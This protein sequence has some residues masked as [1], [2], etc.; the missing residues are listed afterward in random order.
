MQK[1]FGI[2]LILTATTGVLFA[3]GGRDGADAPVI[4]IAHDSSDDARV[5]VYQAVFQQLVDEYN[6]KNGTRY[7]LNYVPGQERDIINTRMSSNDKPDLFSLD[8]PADVNQYAQEGLLLD[9]TPYAD[10]ADWKNTLFGWAYDL[11]KVNDRVVTLPYGYEGMV[12]W[13]NKA[14]MNELGLNPADIGTLDEFEAAME[15]AADAGYIPVMLG[16]QDQ[17]WSQEWYLSILYSYTGRD[18]LKATIEGR[19]SWNDAAFR[20]TVELYRSW[21][22][23]GFLADGKSYVLTIDDAIN[24]FSNDKALF[25]VEGTWAPYWILPLDA[26]AQDKI[27]VMLHPA[28][29]ASERPHM[30]LAVGGMWCVSRDTEHA[31]IAAYILSSL[32]RQEFQGTFIQT[33]MDVAPMNIDTA[34]FR[35]LAPFVER[36]WSIV[37]GALAEGSFGYTTWAFYPPETRI[38]LYEGIVSVLEEDITVDEYLAELQR[39]NT[40]ELNAG[41]TPVIPAATN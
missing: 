33:G 29:N 8:S 40:K 1:F 41:F 6:Q 16:T 20:R 5:T 3:S 35:G 39:L 36:M 22:D 31:D 38:Y 12:L 10:A 9:L 15:K 4:E 30:P 37:N 19:E 13:Y 34:Q 14:I 26:Q 32:L 24:A 25:K 23:K 11:A 27:G 17:P 28:I 21:H 7:V 18:L 2:G